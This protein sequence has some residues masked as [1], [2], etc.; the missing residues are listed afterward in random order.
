MTDGSELTGKIKSFTKDDAMIVVHE[1]GVRKVPLPLVSEP[2]RTQ[3]RTE[4]AE[5]QAEELTEFAEATAPIAAELGKQMGRHMAEQ[6][7]ENYE[8][9]GDEW[10]LVVGIGLVILGAV[11][12]FFASFAESPTWGLCYVLTSGLSWLPFLFC[13]FRRA[14]FPTLVSIAG[15]MSLGWFFWAH[16][17]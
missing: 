16:L 17:P 13:C 11:L 9:T 3:F 10:L 8:S 2:A 15:T 1:N 14:W 5:Q 6:I 12:S 7:A 4:H